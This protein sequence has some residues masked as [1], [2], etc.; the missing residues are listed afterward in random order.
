MLVLDEFPYLAN[1]NT[2]ILSILQHLVD[3]TLRNG[4]LFFVLCG[5]YM[6]FME[7]EVLGAKSPL[8]GRRTGQLHMKPF[9]YKT[10]VE[11]LGGFSDEEKL[12]LYGAVGGAAMYLERVCP[13]VTFKENIVNLFMK[14][15]GYLYEEPQRLLR[16]EVQESGIYNAVIEAIAGGASRADEIAAKCL[17]YINTLCEFGILYKETPYGACLRSYL[18]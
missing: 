14:P 9:D 7:K 5:S 12:Q 17:K 15:T 18:P 4:K 10:S 8:F 13:D 6:G 16:Q 2:G 1:I 3:H 11:F